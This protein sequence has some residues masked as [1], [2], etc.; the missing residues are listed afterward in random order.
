VTE[1]CDLCERPLAQNDKRIKIVYL[2][3][4]GYLEG[5]EEILTTHIT[6]FL[7]LLKMPPEDFLTMVLEKRLK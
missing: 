1:K 4:E 5:G 6:C 2:R 3:R 7:N